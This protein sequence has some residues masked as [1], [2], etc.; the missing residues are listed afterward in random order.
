M[1]TALLGNLV[2]AL[3]GLPFA[4]SVRPT[5]LEWAGLL[6]L[7]IFQ[8]GIPFIL[9]AI[10]IKQLTAVETILIQSLEPI[11]NPIWVFWVVGEAPSAWALLGGLL[12]IGAVTVR[13]LVAVRMTRKETMIATSS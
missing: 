1:E 3:I 9:M 12:V 13:S 5:G 4:F 10:A 8:L 7:G 11:L 2:T 6:F